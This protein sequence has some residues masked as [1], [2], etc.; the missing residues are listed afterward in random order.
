M[1]WG[2]VSLGEYFACVES[3][4]EGGDAEPDMERLK[5]FSAARAH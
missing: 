2:A 4:G 3:S 5:R 1:D